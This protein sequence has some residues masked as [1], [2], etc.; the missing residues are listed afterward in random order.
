LKRGHVPLRTCVACRKKRPK[1]EMMRF[2]AGGVGSVNRD[3]EGR[4]MY[5]CPDISCL[6]KAVSRFDIRKRLGPSAHA[7]VL[8]IL[9]SVTTEENCL[10]GES[11]GG[12]ICDKCHGG[13]VFG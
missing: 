1:V 6:E 8:Q 10:D 13:G 9:E 4:G 3:G 12:V 2:S 7:R 5:L 11:P